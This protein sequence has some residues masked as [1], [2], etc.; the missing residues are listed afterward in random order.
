MGEKLPPLTVQGNG[1]VLSTTKEVLLDDYKT[2][3]ANYFSTCDNRKG[4]NVSRG[5][6]IAWRERKVKTDANM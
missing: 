4:W 1:T 2:D 5:E 3:L 6:V